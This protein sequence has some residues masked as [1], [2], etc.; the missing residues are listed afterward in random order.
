M[1]DHTGK[2]DRSDSRAGSGFAVCMPEYTRAACT[3][4]AWLIGVILALAAVSLCAC[5]I[6]L[7]RL[8]T[9]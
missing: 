7:V 6:T 9:R 5:Q 8:P 3:R 2:A 4:L 1:P